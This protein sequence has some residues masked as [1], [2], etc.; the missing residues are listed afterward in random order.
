MLSPTSPRGLFLTFRSTEP[1]LDSLQ[2][3]N[4]SGFPP[5]LRPVLGR[6][7]NRGRAHVFK[8]WPTGRTRFNRSKESEAE[9]SS[10]SKGLGFR[11]KV[12]RWKFERNPG[13]WGRGFYF[14]TS[15]I[16]THQN[17]LLVSKRD[18]QRMQLRWISTSC[19]MPLPPPL[20]SWPGSKTWRTM[21]RFHLGERTLLYCEWLRKDC[22]PPVARLAS[23]TPANWPRTS[24]AA[25][26]STWSSP[27][28]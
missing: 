3:P 14:G 19:L 8:A 25:D 11:S 17:V 16:A 24:P 6:L 10:S 4:A 5:S 18:S 23:A 20:S 26:A 7:P 28:R 1:Q 2:S 13:L 27:L 21:A 22:K 9:G 15:Y 12:P